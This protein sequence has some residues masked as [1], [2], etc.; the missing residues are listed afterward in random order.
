M[1]LIKIEN[2]FILNFN[3]FMALINKNNKKRSKFVGVSWSNNMKMWKA[4][5]MIDGKIKHLGLFDDE[6]EAACKYDEQAALYY[7][8]VNFPQY[9]GQ[10][11][12]VKVATPRDLSTVPDV[13]KRSKFV[14]VS[15]NKKNKKWIAVITIDGK[16]K[17]LG[18]FDYEKEAACN[19]DE[20]AVIYNKP[21]NF[22][23]Y[24]GQKQAVKK[25][26][27]RDLSKVPDVTRSSE[28]VGV[29]WYKRHRKW[30]AQIGIDGTMKNLGYFDD[31]KEAARNYDE[32]AA[33]YNRPVNFPQHNGQKQVIK[34]GK[35]VQINKLDSSVS[36]NVPYVVQPSKYVGVTWNKDHKKW[37]ARI[38]IDNKKINLGTF[39][40]QED[41][42]HKYDEQATLIGKPVNFPKEGQNRA[43][44]RKYCRSNNN[45][46]SKQVKLNIIS[47]I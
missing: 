2:Y 39:E 24:E 8:P 33:L 3:E 43:L 5:I 35:N 41:A 21:V 38:H 42:A 34:W 9:E 30:K 15:W 46:K 14:G 32:Q 36:S 44:K 45:I 10:E 20:E 47:P 6:K 23:Q 13:M 40:N 16:N 29:T 28:F 11:Q 4:E 7:K 1:L 12:A 31:E 18:M 17:K 22:P 37:T 27:R 19:Y 26:L 25:A